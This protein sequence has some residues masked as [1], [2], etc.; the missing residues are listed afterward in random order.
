ML[1]RNAR[2]TKK[3]QTGTASAEKKDMPKLSFK[4]VDEVRAYAKERPDRIILVFEGR[5]VC[6]VTEFEDHPGGIDVFSDLVADGDI[7]I[8]KHM[9]SARH[10]TAAM[11]KVYDFK[12][13][14]IEP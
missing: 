1:S 3:Q 13:G 9:E 10:S 14:A 11:M 5:I 4:S 8:K 2:N 7:E 12:I 6:D